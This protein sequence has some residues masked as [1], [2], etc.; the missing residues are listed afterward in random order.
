M[1]IIDLINKYPTRQAAADAAGVNRVTIHN[2]ISGRT[3][4][5]WFTFI[6]LCRGVG[7]DPMTVVAEDEAQ[8]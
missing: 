8:G 2:Y 5:K 7:V 3:D 1:I 6:A 4:P